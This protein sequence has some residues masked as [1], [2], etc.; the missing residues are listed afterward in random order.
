MNTKEDAKA[1]LDEAIGRLLK[2]WRASKKPKYMSYE[3]FSKFLVAQGEFECF[4]YPD[5][6]KKAIIGDFV[7]VLTRSGDPLSAQLEDILATAQLR[8]VRIFPKEEW[9]YV[10]VCV[11]F[12]DSNAEW[13][14]PFQLAALWDCFNMLK[15]Y[16]FISMTS[17]EGCNPPEFST[18]ETP[19]QRAKREHLRKC[20]ECA[21]PPPRSQTPQPTT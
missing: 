6:T 5:E 21:I 8:E 12:L 9:M 1:K 11:R 3:D 14:E 15:G 19:A 16:T 7:P 17:K 2:N 10:R 13:G 18:P 20:R 4:D